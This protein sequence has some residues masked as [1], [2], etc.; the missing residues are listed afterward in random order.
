MRILG[1]GDITFGTVDVGVADEEFFDEWR[2]FF[3]DDVYGLLITMLLLIK[4][5]VIFRLERLLEKVLV[6]LMLLEEK[7]CLY[8]FL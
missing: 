3:K 5:K 2:V 1:L 7:L 8:I 4:I 6:D